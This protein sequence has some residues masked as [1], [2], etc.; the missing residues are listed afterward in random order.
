MQLNN[1]GRLVFLSFFFFKILIQMMME[2]SITIAVIFCILSA[3]E[4]HRSAGHFSIK[5]R[6]DH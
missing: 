3:I 5:T 6:A 1:M 2:N 4:K